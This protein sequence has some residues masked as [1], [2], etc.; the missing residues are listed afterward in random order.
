MS[1]TAT[2]AVLTIRSRIID[3]D[4]YCSG[5]ENTPSVRVVLKT[6]KLPQTH[7]HRFK[8][9]EIIT[10]YHL[11]DSYVEPTEVNTEGS[12][13]CDGCNYWDDVGINHDSIS[14][15]VCAIATTL[16]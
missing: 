8:L 7:L 3:H 12:G 15:V 11:F 9:G 6:V 4:G 2:H 1:Y 14:D 5:E 13:Y 10:G 16:E